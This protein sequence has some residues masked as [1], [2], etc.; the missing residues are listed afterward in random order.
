MWLCLLCRYHPDKNANDAAAADVFKGVTF[1]YGILSD[2]NKRCQYDT[3]GFEVR[4]TSSF[5]LSLSFKLFLYWFT[6]YYLFLYNSAY[7]YIYIP[8]LCLF[9][10]VILAP[11][12]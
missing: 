11:N 6:C 2:P 4:D 1:A 10:P 3:S 12:G 5:I 9:H 7:S 8:L